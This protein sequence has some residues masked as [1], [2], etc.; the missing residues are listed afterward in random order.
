[1]A[2]KTKDKDYLDYIEYRIIRSDGSV[3]NLYLSVK[4]EINEQGRH[5]RHYG[6]IQDITAIRK[7]EQEKNRLTSII[8]VTPDIVAILDSNGGLIYLNQSGRYFYG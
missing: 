8:E 3:R 1:R 7:T 4:V 6:T 5:T 2:L